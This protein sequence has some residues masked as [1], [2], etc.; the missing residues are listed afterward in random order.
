[1]CDQFHE[2]TLPLAASGWAGRDISELGM[3]LSRIK[4]ADGTPSKVFE[5]GSRNLGPI[6]AIWIPMVKAKGEQ[7]KWVPTITPREILNAEEMYKRVGESA[8]AYW[9]DPFCPVCHGA[10]QDADRRTCDPCK[11]TGVAELLMGRRDKELALDL[12]S[13]L[14]DM[15]QSH[16]R[17]SAYILRESD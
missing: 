13:E 15:L 14:E 1:M 9:L 16:S 10:K 3:L 5:S 2:N 6:L 8:L 7:R 12:V 17:R 4:Y 11:G